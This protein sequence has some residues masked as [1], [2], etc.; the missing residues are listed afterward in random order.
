MWK[1]KKLNMKKKA[2]QRE[3]CFTKISMQ[4]KEIAKSIVYV[5]DVIQ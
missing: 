2:S 4:V 3:K 5:F 1:E